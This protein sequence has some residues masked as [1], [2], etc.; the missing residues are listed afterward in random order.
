MKFKPHQVLDT[1]D[2]INIQLGDF[3]N[4]IVH[5]YYEYYETTML[6]FGDEIVWN[7]PYFIFQSF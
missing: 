7:I 2:Y 6:W 1:L 3:T 5:F 4:V